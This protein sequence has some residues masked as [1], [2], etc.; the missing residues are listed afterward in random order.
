MESFLKRIKK[1]FVP[2]SENH[3]EPHFLRHE[4][5]MVFF[6]MIIVIELGFLVQ[7]FI[8][9]DK[10]N[11]L[12][13]VLPGVLT[14]ITNEERQQNDA[15]PLKENALLKEAA[16]LK[17]NDMATNGYF[18]H[19]SPDGKT[20]WY[21]FDQVGYKY[22]YAGENLA[23]NFF[24][25]SDVAQAWMN[26]PSHREN[27][28]KKAY[29]EIG[30][31][32]ANGVYQGRQ[33]VFVA[34]LFG[35][36][37][38]AYTPPAPSPTVATATPTPAPT[39]STVK[40]KPATTPKTTPVTKP[41]TVVKATPKPTPTTTP[42]TNPNPTGIASAPISPN[43]TQVLGE[44]ATTASVQSS[45]IVPILLAIEKVLTSPRQ[46]VAY[47]YGAIALITVF[48][49]LMVLFVVS[50]IRHP[51]MIL[52]GIG[53]VSV[54]VLLLFA[55]LKIIHIETDIPTGNITANAIAH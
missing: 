46:S 17:A 36:P 47:A 5:I 19:T 30:I 7:V 32:V 55:N 20:P 18:A 29:T 1:D 37:L 41:T 38:E 43:A 24:E 44:T 27:I 50:E 22:S 45:K 52:R 39:T 49:L 12:A 51:L 54:I 9:F 14:S 35:T 48:S 42:S 34:Q 13:S 33:T 15:P 28:V 25:S 6:L 31:G 11:F 40:P 10:T 26:S 4:S 8:V 16:Q 23:V 53:L 3:Y 21:W 2:H